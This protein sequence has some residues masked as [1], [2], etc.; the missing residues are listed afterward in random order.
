MIDLESPISVIHRNPSEDLF[1]VG[2]KSFTKIIKIVN[3]EF[4]VHKVLKTAKSSS[5]VGTTDIQWNKSF[6]TILASTTL[7]NSSILIW[8]ISQISHDKLSTTIG[9]HD[10]IINRISWNNINY[11]ILASCSQ[12]G[13]I[14]L[15]DYKVKEE[16][17]SINNK[18]KIRDCQFSPFSEFQLLAS[19]NNGIINLWDTRK[20]DSSVSQFIRH[21]SDVLSIDWNP[22]KENIFVSG[23]TDKNLYIW[24]INKSQPILNYK[25]NFGTNRVKWYKKNP[26]Y[27]LTSYQ[28]NNNFAALWNTKI[29]NIPEYLFKGHKEVVTGFSWSL[30]ESKLITVSKDSKM[31]LHDFSNG[32]RP[33]D[34]FFSNFSKLIDDNNLIFYSDVLPE[35]ENIVNKKVE[36]NITYEKSKKTKYSLNFISFKMS[37]T[38]HKAIVNDIFRSYR[39]ILKSNLVRNNDNLMQFETLSEQIRSIIQHNV[40]SSKKYTYSNHFIIFN[41]LEFLTQSDFFNELCN[42]TE[43]SNRIEGENKQKTHNNSVLYEVYKNNLLEIINF[44]IELEN[45]IILATII[46]YIFQ[47]VFE[48]DENLIKKITI[49]CIE[50]IKSFSLFTPAVALIKFSKSTIIKTLNSKSCLFLMSC[51]LCNKK[52]DSSKYPFCNGCNKRIRC[53]IC[54]FAVEG[55]IFWSPSC[56]HGGHVNHMKEWFKYNSICPLCL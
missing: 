33:L 51:K 5:K 23:S 52:Y 41:E 10:Q 25:T 11:K 35:K 28:T 30:D 15:F 18:E 7:L 31:I 4:K 2:G 45:D 38:Y 27:I 42:M 56:S 9:S 20:T 14:K 22:L 29:F 16:V 55:L 44:L 17:L 32:F 37:F 12:D 34:N 40:R 48:F 43:E 6:K 46:I 49:G 8:D 50:Y 54:S 19:Y 47:D 21:E 53:A 26:Q 1:A 13:Y 36:E 39:F 24:D 3:N